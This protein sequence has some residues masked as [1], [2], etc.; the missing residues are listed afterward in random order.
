[1]SEIVVT[2]NDQGRTIEVHPDDVIVLRLDEN[3]TTGHSWELEPT[4]SSVI[5]LIDSTH[6]AAPAIAMGQGGVRTVRFAARAAGSRDVGLRLRRPW[7]P[8]DN[9]LDRFDVT[10]RVRT[11][12][13]R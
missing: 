6:T 8:P 10:V 3:L 9:A 7:E 1:M 5:E 11:E 12:A 2:R 13:G 4:D